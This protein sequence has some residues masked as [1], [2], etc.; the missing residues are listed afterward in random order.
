VL[1]EVLDQGPGIAPEMRE[2][3]FDRFAKFRPEGYEEVPGPGLGLYIAR[4]HARELGGEL[5]VQEAPSGTMLRIEL[6]RGGSSG[7]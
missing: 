7:G 2:R 3:A 6:P 1:V 4:A 5:A